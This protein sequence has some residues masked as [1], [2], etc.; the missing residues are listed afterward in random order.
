MKN[1]IIKYGLLGGI[2]SILGI[3]I[4]S[5]TGYGMGENPVISSIVSVAILAVLIYLALISM[6]ETRA[7][8]GGR[9]G[10]GKAFVTALL[11][12][13][14]TLNNF[15]SYFHFNYVEENYE[16][17]IKT[18]TLQKMQE[19]FEKKGVPEDTQEMILSKI[20]Q[21]S[22]AFD[23]KKLL[24]SLISIAVF[25]SIVSL[26]LAAILKKDISSEEQTDMLET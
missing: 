16:E 1:A 15:Y 20:E 22:F 7:E 21:R 18:A 13:S 19:R 11:M 9:I 5:F 23:G 24:L 17:R 8:L 10:F 2:L 12:L 25:Y 3:L 6:K 14:G 4:L 26:I